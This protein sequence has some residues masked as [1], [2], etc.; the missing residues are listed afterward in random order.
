[1]IIIAHTNLTN[2]FPVSNLCFE[3]YTSLLSTHQEIIQT[4]KPPS[5][6]EGFIR[7]ED[8]VR[9]GDFWYHKPAL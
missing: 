1:M 8:R 5:F 2:Q 6:L 7:V 4:K 3:V 9:T